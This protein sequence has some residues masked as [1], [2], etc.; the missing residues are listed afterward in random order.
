MSE[1][2][3]AES[4]RLA[5]PVGI[6]IRSR[7]R[8]L[9]RPFIRLRATYME[10]QQ[11]RQSDQTA[12]PPTA[13]PGTTTQ[14]VKPT[15]VTESKVE[16]Q[17][18]FEVFAIFWA[19]ASLL[20][21]WIRFEAAMAS[22]WLVAINATI[23]I[24]AFCILFRPDWVL[25]VVVLSAMH[26]LYGIVE[27]P[28]ISTAHTIWMFFSAV[29]CTS[30]LSGMVLRRS[31]R[32][33]AGGLYRSVGPAIR[34]MT[35]LSLVALAVARL[36]WGFLG[37]ETSPVVESLARFRGGSAP[38]DWVVYLTMSVL[39][40]VELSLAVTLLVPALRRFGLGFGSCY[41][42]WQAALGLG[43]AKIL[44]PVLMVGLGMF[45]SADLV[46]RMQTGL[47]R[48]LPLGGVR[49]FG[50]GLLAMVISVAL[51]ILAWKRREVAELPF[52]GSEFLESE[53]VIG[54]SYWIVSLA[55]L[56]LLLTC[57]I[58]LRPKLTWVSFGVRNPLNILLIL[59]FI[60]AIVSPYTGLGTVGRFV[61]QSGFASAE[62]ASNHLLIPAVSLFD[63][64]QGLIEVISSS[65]PWLQEIAD[66]GQLLS[67]FDL[68]NYVVVR[69]D[70][71]IAFIRENEH[72]QVERC[73][74]ITELSVANPWIARKLIS[75]RPLNRILIP[76]SQQQVAT[77]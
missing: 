12:H 18:Q 70:T 15:R 58:D 53:F 50:L 59:G 51:C 48:L 34:I 3:G 37:L 23:W 44:L 28:Q 32:V 49:R 39:L 33:S 1:G 17:Q 6:R 9:N 73:G 24:S 69:P 66:S 27:M 72:F 57:L 76:A 29:V 77:R 13:A 68:V 65:D 26:V 67:W 74:D 54:G 20:S 31:Y 36:N 71:S 4:N 7:R 21:G 42:A 10:S 11:Y 38:P 8:L 41:L 75:F 52:A 30:F 56:G 14:P 62:G 16:V 63:C 60:I 64:H 5:S 35:V 25:A 43:E 2:T 19:M 22:P 45:A 46:T 40:V 55:W 47:R 61:D